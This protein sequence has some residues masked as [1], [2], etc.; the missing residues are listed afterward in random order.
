MFLSADRHHESICSGASGHCLNLSPCVTQTKPQAALGPLCPMARPLLVVDLL[1]PQRDA[2]LLFQEVLP[3]GRLRRVQL[4]HVRGWHETL[5]I[6]HLHFPPV[7][8]G[9]KERLESQFL[10]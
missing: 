2:A 3:G 7:L 4:L 5:T 10:P 1:L 8:S 6:V 9:K